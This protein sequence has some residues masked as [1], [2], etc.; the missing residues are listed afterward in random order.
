MG[1]VYF[2]TNPAD[3]SKLE[4]LYVS[5]RR[6]AGFI[7]GRDLSTIGFAGKCVRGPLD[8]QIIGSTGQFLDIYGGRDYGSGG[9]VIGEV[10]K[11]L[12]NKPFG[13]FVVRRVAA[14]DAVKASFTDETAAGGG[15]T[16]VLTVRASSVGLWGNDVLYK[17]ADATDGDSDHF[18]LTVSYLG[19]ETLYENLDISTG[20]DNLAA[21]VGSEP[22]RVVDLVKVANGRPVNTAA[23]TDGAN[24][25]GYIA[26]GQTTITGFTGVA[27]SE[28]TLAVKEYNNAR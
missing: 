5:E 8:V 26:L 25:D 2:T 19:K 23:S 17:I 12:L 24:S 13:P 28:G 22:E 3:F 4:G 6:P 27:G 10:W 7:R 18:N 11:A 14:A 9:T 1:D 21:K 20:N 16:Q 15:G